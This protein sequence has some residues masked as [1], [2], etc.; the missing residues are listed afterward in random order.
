MSDAQKRIKSLNEKQALKV[1]TRYD[2]VRAGLQRMTLGSLE[3]TQEIRSFFE[4][5]AQRSAPT[6]K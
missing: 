1:E 4:H 6:A 3:A 2:A 5:P